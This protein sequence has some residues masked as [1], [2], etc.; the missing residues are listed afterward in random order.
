[1][2]LHVWQAS[3][4]LLEAIALEELSDVQSLKQ[5]LQKK[6][7]KPRFRQ[8]LIHDGSSLYSLA[9]DFLCCMLYCLSRTRRISSDAYLQKQGSP[10][11]P[12]R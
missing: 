8:R 5:R 1:M 12:N 10:G 6:C 4:E 3:G 9:K 7:G 2:M 11:Y